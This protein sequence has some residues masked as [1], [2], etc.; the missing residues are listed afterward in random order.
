VD[1]S[2]WL[3]AFTGLTTVLKQEISHD[4]LQSA[5]DCNRRQFKN[6]HHSLFVMCHLHEG[7]SACTMKLNIHEAIC[8][9]G[10]SW[11]IRGAHETSHI[12]CNTRIAK[13][14][15]RCSANDLLITTSTAQAR[16]ISSI[17]RRPSHH[18]TCIARS[19]HQI[20]LHHRGAKR[21]S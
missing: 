2:K 9:A 1:V 15:M 19:R 21:G 10:V 4:S 14:S 7:N 20:S 17:T 3:Q 12:T 18:F 6:Q 8:G 13:S 5:D 11:T 16:Q